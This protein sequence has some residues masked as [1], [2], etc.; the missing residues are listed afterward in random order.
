MT[1]SRE[2]LNPRREGRRR[3]EGILTA[4]GTPKGY[5]YPA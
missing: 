3:Y 4:L 2:V 5:I 1:R